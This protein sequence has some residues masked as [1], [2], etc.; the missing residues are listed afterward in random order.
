MARSPSVESDS[1]H[2]PSSF[3]QVERHYKARTPPG[4][5]SGGQLRRLRKGQPYRPS[6]EDVWDV[7]ELLDDGDAPRENGPWGRAQRHGV[8]CVEVGLDGRRGWA[9]K[10]VSGTILISFTPFLLPGL[11][12]SCCSR[13]SHSQASSSSLNTSP[14]QNNARSSSPAWLRTRKNPIRPTCISTTTSLPLLAPSGHFT[15]L[16]SVRPRGPRPQTNLSSI[17]GTPRQIVRSLRSSLQVE[18]WS[19]TL[20]A[21]NSHW[22]RLLERQRVN[23]SRRRRSSPPRSLS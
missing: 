18:P 21:S 3:R 13:P 9:V 16:P 7:R 12:Q 10:D 22:K 20:Q 15:R 6:L 19:T 23:R 1:Q 11:T 2:Q 4:P 17:L 14:L 8:E 5:L